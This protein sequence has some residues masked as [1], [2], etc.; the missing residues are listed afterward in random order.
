MK[1]RIPLIMQDQVEKEVAQSVQTARVENTE[2]GV[3][4]VCKKQMKLS[5]ADTHQ[6]LVCIDH[7]IVMPI[8]DDAGL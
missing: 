7:S 8:K 2:Y 1:R 5:L 6:V 4:P 3:C